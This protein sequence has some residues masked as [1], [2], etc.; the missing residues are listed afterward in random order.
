MGV[1]RWIHWDGHGLARDFRR[2]GVYQFLDDKIGRRCFNWWIPCNQLAF[3]IA[4]ILIM[5]P[6]FDYLYIFLSYNFRWNHTRRT[7]LNLSLLCP[8]NRLA[9]NFRRWLIPSCGPF[10]CWALIFSLAGFWIRVTLLINLSE[11]WWLMASGLIC[12]IPL[13]DGP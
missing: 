7:A 6:D 9:N 5:L 10:P 12:P 1:G 2:S 13:T 3:S 8:S 4:V 11:V